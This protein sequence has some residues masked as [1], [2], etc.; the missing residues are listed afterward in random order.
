[1]KRVLSWM[2]MTGGLMLG[3]SAVAPSFAAQEGLAAPDAARGGTL[4][5]QGDASRGIISCASCHGPGG[6]STIEAN[7]KLA[8]QHAGYLHGQLIDLRQLPDAEAPSRISP[9]M[10]PMAA[11][12]TDQDIADIS[13]YLSQKTLDNPATATNPALVE[14][15]QKIWRGGIMAKGV[16]AC[17]ACHGASGTGIPAQYPYLGGQFASYLE[18]QLHAFRSGDRDGDRDTGGVMADIA[19]RLSDAEIKAVSDYAAGLR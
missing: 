6:D 18:S 1:M 4:Y 15:G 17:S 9:V 5:E 14:A 16:P 11:N 8:G 3:A 12:L 7:P 10:N 13:Y 19:A 2:V